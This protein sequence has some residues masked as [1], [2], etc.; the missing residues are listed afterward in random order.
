MIEEKGAGWL[1][2]EVPNAL[3]DQILLLWGERAT[4]ARGVP[5]QNRRQ[6]VFG[7]YRIESVEEEQVGYRTQWRVRPYR[8]GWTQ[9]AALHIDMPRYEKIGGPYLNQLEERTVDRMF[10]ETDLARKLDPRHSKRFLDFCKGYPDWKKSARKKAEALCEK[11]GSTPESHAPIRAYSPPIRNQAL[12][13]LRELFP[14]GVP[15]I[16]APG[17]SQSMSVVAD[18]PAAPMAGRIAIDPAQLRWIDETLG[19]DLCMELQVAFIT[20]ELVILRGA[21][22]VGKSHLAL[23]LL[24]DPDRERTLVVPVSATWRGREDLL[25]YVNPIDGK[26]VATPFTEFLD[27]SAQAWERGDRSARVVVFEEFNLSQPEHWLADILTI[28]QYEQEGDRRIQLA[29]DGASKWRDVFL[30]PA[31]RF[32]A[33]VN[34]DHTTRSLSPRVLDRAAVVLLELTAKEALERVGLDLSEPALEAIADID[35][36]LKSKGASFSIRTAR[37][38]AT[39][40]TSGLGMGEL[41][42][43]DLV[44]VQQVLSKVCLTAHDLSDKACLEALERWCERAGSG[45]VRCASQVTS[46]RLSLDSGLDV[47]QA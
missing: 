2:R 40:L 25:G 21:P 35:F 33:T 1:L 10:S 3:D 12:S 30:S 37:A 43:T 22:G 32:V 7:A 27:R 19:E 39:C 46:W 14:D 16:A 47:Q 36:I 44:L 5:D 34:S 20:R 4:H 24:D 42:A 18:A 45:M 23:R 31:I 15:P 11:L 28:S 13:G 8:D 38:L 17:V 9:F 6:V 29:G 26:F 41:D